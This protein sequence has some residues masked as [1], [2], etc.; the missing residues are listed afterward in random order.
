MRPID[1]LEVL[2]LVE[3]PTNWSRS[4]LANM[5]RIAV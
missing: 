5:P 2:V 4:R 1:R 3:S